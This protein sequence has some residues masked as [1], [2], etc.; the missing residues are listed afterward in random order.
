[1]EQM[2]KQ[3]RLSESKKIILVVKAVFCFLIIIWLSKCIYTDGV[4]AY[5]SYKDYDYQNEFSEFV[6]ADGNQSIDQAFVSKGNVLSNLKLYFGEISD[7][8]LS[9]SINDKN[10]R[11]LCSKTI[12]VGGGTFQTRGM[13][14]PLIAAN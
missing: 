4:D 2:T 10:G 7:S 6:L 14:F 13:A 5:F 3:K 12:N 11:T 9:I 8:E 1:M